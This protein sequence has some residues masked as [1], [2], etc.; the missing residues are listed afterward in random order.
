VLQGFPPLRK[1]VSA[2][3]FWYDIFSHV[4]IS[5]FGQSA[6][7]M[8]LFSGSECSYNKQNNT[9]IMLGDM[10]FI[11]LCSSSILNEWYWMNDIEL[12]YIHVAHLYM[13]IY[14]KALYTWNNRLQFRAQF[15][16]HAVYNH[17]W[18]LVMWSRH[19]G[20]SL[21]EFLYVL[22]GSFMSLVR[23]AH[24]WAWTL[25]DKLHI[26]ARP[27][28]IFYLILLCTLS[29]LCVK[30]FLNNFSFWCLQSQTLTVNRQM[31]RYNVPCV[32]FI[33]KLDRYSVYYTFNISW[34]NDYW[35]QKH[36]RQLREQATQHTCPGR[37]LKCLLTVQ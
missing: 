23:C 7:S 32:A 14:S 12:I 2:R 34:N 6:I 28:I 33:N 11:F 29:E 36:L 30:Y 9:Q 15:C 21:P 17:E 22:S 13:W 27:C 19:W 37:R 5:S 31:K 20:W 3:V 18:W 35:G 1:I 10:K 26:S 25:E 8:I 24:S 16:S 4:L